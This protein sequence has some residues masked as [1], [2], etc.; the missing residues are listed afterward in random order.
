MLFLKSKEEIKTFSDKQNLREVITIGLVL[1]E[2]S[3]GV[4]QAER[5]EY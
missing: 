5:K 1:Q 2:T 3:K 4:F